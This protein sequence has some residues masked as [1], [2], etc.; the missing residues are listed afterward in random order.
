LVT[1][2][3]PDRSLKQVQKEVKPFQIVSDLSNSVMKD[4]QVYYELTPELNKV[5]VERLQFDLAEYNGKNRYVLPVPATFIIDR[6]AVI[7]AK[8]ANV[9]YTERME[10]AD[11]LAALRTIKGAD[12]TT[13][14]DDKR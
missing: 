9:D 7:R 14:D 12:A 5:Y 4:Y 2:Q 6:Q 13:S 11:I 1:P 8:H 10:P 3:L